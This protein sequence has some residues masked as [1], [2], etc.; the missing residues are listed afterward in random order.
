M[1]YGL[2]KLPD[3]RRNFINEPFQYFQFRNYSIVIS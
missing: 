2:I 3:N 1:D